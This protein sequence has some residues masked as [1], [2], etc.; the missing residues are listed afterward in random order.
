MSSL[1]LKQL[2]QVWRSPS[3]LL[4]VLTVIG[5]DIVKS[6]LAQLAGGH[7]TPV[8]FSFG[9]VGYSFSSLSVAVGENRLMPPVDY[10]SIVVNGK[11]GYVRN[12]NSWMLGRIL[13]D[14]DYWRPKEVHRQLKAM[15]KELSSPLHR[16]PGLCISVFETT[17]GKQGQASMDWVYLSGILVVIIQLIV[18]T[19]PWIIFD[20]FVPFMVTAIGV[21]LCLLQGALPQWKAEKWMCRRRKKEKTVILTAGNGALHVLVIIGKEGA[22]DLEDLATAALPSVQH[23]RFLVPLL[24]LAWLAHL[25]TVTGI[26]ENPWFFLAVGGIG[27][28]HNVVVAGAPRRPE[29]FGLHLDFRE[30]ILNRKVM[31]SLMT[32]E[33]NHPGLGACLL[34]IFFPGSLNEEEQKFWDEKANIWQ[35][36]LK[37][38]STSEPKEVK[39]S[40]ISDS[41]PL[42]K[43]LEEPPDQTLLPV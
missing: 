6:A 10:P 4:S 24:A 37:H 16:L 7:I 19:I 13:R 38:G 8:S 1:S 33:E 40:D 5:G 41:K 9:W 15:R 12:N 42:Q 26:N 22:L 14:F 17:K 27:M 36:L 29:A 23:T 34:P 32:L 3:D 28:V 43:S 35:A 20:D 39:N 21:V 2:S 25:I 30:C 18:A 31:K 11:N